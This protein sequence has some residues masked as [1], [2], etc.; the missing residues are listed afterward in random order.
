MQ[1]RYKTDI[2][3]MNSENSETFYPYISLFN[4]TNK[5]DLRRGENR[6]ALFA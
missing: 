4:L 3:F 1:Y 2:L 6:F 5:I